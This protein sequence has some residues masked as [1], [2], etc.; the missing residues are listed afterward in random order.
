MGVKVREKV[1]GSGV[2]WI[3]VNHNGRRT[4]RQVGTKN[5]ADKAKEKIEAKLTLNE[6]IPEEK[7]KKHVPTLESFYQGL[8]E[9]H[10]AM[11]VRDSTAESYAGNFRLHILP[12]LGKL[13]LDEIDRDRIK[14]FV[15]HLTKKTHSRMVKVRTKDPKSGNKVVTEKII[16][17]PYSKASI[18]IFLSELCAV[19]NH[20]REDA[21]I[22]SNPA[23]RLTKFYKQTNVV[24]EEIQPLTAEEIPL[25][26]AAAKKTAVQFYPLFLCALHTGMRSGEL[27][28]LRWSDI[29]FNGRFIRL[30]KNISRGKIGGT[31]TGKSRRVDVSDDLLMTLESLQRDRKEEY[32]ARGKNEIP[33]WVFLSAGKREKEGKHSEGRRVEM[34]NVKH[35]HFH[36]C[37]AKA[38]LRRIRFHD[39]RHT[40]ATLLLMQ[41]ESLVYVKDQLGHS[42][43][44]MTVD[45]YG[46]WIPGS[47]R[48]AVNRLPSLQTVASAVAVS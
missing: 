20:A 4:S 39:L 45:T 1:A 3:F 42:S 13:R 25:F 17:A 10:F 27:A 47:N 23:E 48:Q 43:I 14:Q 9:T 35:R 7:P 36:K 15:A 22:I 21:W 40:Y 34:H 26:L 33:E 18:R 8:T 19:L 29:D 37:L 6:W 5:A 31:K 46:H 32:L 28:A 11:A 16:E 24:H 44:K 2:Y 30:Q 41:G 38:G 12:E